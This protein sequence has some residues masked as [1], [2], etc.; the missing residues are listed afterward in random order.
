MASGIKDFSVTFG[1]RMVTLVLSIASQSCLAWGLGVEGRGAYAVCS[2]IPALLTLLFMLGCDV[3]VIYE[4]AS[5]RQS[6]SQGVMHITIYGL[7]ASAV[8]IVAGIVCI[9]LRVPIFTKVAPR[10]LYL[11]LATIPLSFLAGVFAILLTSIR[12]FVVSAVF[13]II[14]GVLHVA[15]AVLFV[16]ILDWQVIG[17]ILSLVVG[18][19][20]TLVGILAVMRKRYGLRLVRPDL[21]RIRD[22]LH[23]G[24]RYYLG[25]LSNLANVELG[26]ILLALFAT[27]AEIGLFAVASQ[28]TSQA[29]VIPN[30][31]SVV[32][33]PR[34]AST[35]G[36]RPDLVAQ[37]ARV[38]F[39]VCGALL[40]VLTVF[41][42]P[43]IYV[44]FSPDF[45][46]SVP[47]IRILVLGVLLR[48]ASKLFVPYLNGINRPGIA[49]FAVGAGVLVNL[50][51][52][53]LLLPR[54]GLSGAAI[55]MCASYV[56]SSAIL[57]FTFR[58]LSGLSLWEIVRPRKSDWE[59]MRRIWDRLR[60]RG[61][62][63]AGP[64]V[65]IDQDRMSP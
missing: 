8:A 49:S 27:K 56:V 26:T 55:A 59:P 22:M 28:A 39:L 7:S 61:A 25:K 16:L 33:F 57:T 53:V 14:A 10:E 64:N 13:S 31:L 42:T 63:E 32:L 18:N 41:A 6:L 17:A 44:L 35:P 30:T 52:V 2:L 9:H 19:S 40:A 3:G 54:I 23:Y 36:G 21:A 46:G 62:A 51:L 24:L 48:C 45:L 1:A 65:S 38:S 11:A 12:E 4:V 34:V 47:L 37:S 5:K 43:L 29:E 58:R 15:L 20:L 60:G 50:A